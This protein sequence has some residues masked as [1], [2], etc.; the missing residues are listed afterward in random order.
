MEKQEE[1]GKIPSGCES[2]RLQ[3]G[4]S[5]V[6]HL[7]KKKMFKDQIIGSNSGSNVIHLLQKP[8]I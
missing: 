7:E 1:L 2:G 3:D 5:G 4:S 8:E 6:E